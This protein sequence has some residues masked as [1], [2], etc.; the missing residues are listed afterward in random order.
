VKSRPATSRVLVA[1]AVAEGYAAGRDDA[2]TPYRG[3]FYH[4]MTSQGKNAPGGAKS[5]I[6]NGKMSSGFAFVAY[7]AGYRSSGVMTFIVGEDGVVY[8]QG[9]PLRGGY[10]SLKLS[11]SSTAGRCRVGSEAQRGPAA[12]AVLSL[13]RSC[14]SISMAPALA[15]V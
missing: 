6:A 11:Q 3:Y 14:P 5:Y 13:E 8:Q 4:I 15:I 2:P 1:S 12:K 7:P 10:L 9:P